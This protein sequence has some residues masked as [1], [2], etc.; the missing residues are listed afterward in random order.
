MFSEKIPNGRSIEA[1]VK[2]DEKYPQELVAGYTALVLYER[3]FCLYMGDISYKDIW[4]GHLKDSLK[5]V[6]DGI[7]ESELV[8]D[9]LLFIYKEGNSPTRITDAA[10]KWHP[11][12]I[13]AL[14]GKDKYSIEDARIIIDS[15]RNG[16]D[17]VYACLGVRRIWCEDW[18]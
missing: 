13:K 6:E 8:A 11:R 17:S 10:W 1:L 12:L 2:E 4:H 9:N 5:Y 14:T 16:A 18:H 3:M 15:M 7:S